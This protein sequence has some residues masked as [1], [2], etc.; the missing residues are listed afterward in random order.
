[1]LHVQIQA[2]LYLLCL[3]YSMFLDGKGITIPTTQ[4]W[5]DVPT[6]TPT[7]VGGYYLIPNDPGGV[8]VVQ[9]KLGT[10]KFG[11]WVYSV[12][13]GGG[14]ATG[15]NAGSCVNQISAPDPIPAV[16]VSASTG[17]VLT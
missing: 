3:Y 16:S 4:K 10:L 5:V 12:R 14:C 7:H 1:V 13:P 2:Y 15:F 11:A 17:K 8:H 6:L 9:H